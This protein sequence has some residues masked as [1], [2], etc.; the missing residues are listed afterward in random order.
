M[1]AMEMVLSGGAQ[2]KRKWG[3]GLLGGPTSQTVRREEGPWSELRTDSTGLGLEKSLHRGL[4]C[5]HSLLS[6]HSE[7]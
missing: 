5:K 6:V 1:K 7:G 4:Q 2:S 3:E